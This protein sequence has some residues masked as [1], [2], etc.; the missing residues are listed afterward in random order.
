MLMNPAAEVLISICFDCYW[1]NV[2]ILVSRG[3]K[4]SN[5][6]IEASCSE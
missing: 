1:D 4:F 3:V 5:E 6:S 2:H